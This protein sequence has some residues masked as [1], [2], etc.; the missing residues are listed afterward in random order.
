MTRLLQSIKALHAVRP[1]SLPTGNSTGLKYALLP[2]SRCRRR[3]SLRHCR[4]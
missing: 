4:C 1:N 2:D 3:S